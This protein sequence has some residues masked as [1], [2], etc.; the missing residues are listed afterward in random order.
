MM[1]LRVCRSDSL[2]CEHFLEW[3][4]HKQIETPCLA[5]WLWRKI[6]KWQ[7]DGAEFDGG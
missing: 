3:F 6:E 5:G 1:W 2:A 4:N 7:W